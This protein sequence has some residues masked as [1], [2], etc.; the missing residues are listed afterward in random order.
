[1]TDHPLHEFVSDL[2]RRL[3][4]RVEDQPELM[5]RDAF[6]N[7]VTEYLVEDGSLDDLDPCYLHMTWGKR[8]VET[9]GYDISDDESILHL[10]V[11]EYGMFGSVLRR[12][13]VDQM[14]RRAGA[15]VD[16]CREGQHTLLEPSSPAYDMVERIHTAWSRLQSVKILVLTDGVTNIRKMKENPVGG[17]PTSVQVWDLERLHRLMGVSMA[18]EEIVINLDEL[19]HAVPCLE[20]PEQADGY[21][22]LMA[23]FPGKLLADL[24][25][26]HHSRLLQ[27]NVRAYL[28]A[29]G[30]INKKI[31]ETIKEEPGRFLAYNN[32]VS[33]TAKSATLVPGPNGPILASLT[34]LQIVNGGQTTASLHHAARKGVPLDAVHV[35]AKITLIAD[36]TLDPMIPLISKYAN[37]QNAVTSADFE[38]NSVFHVGLERLSRTTWATKPDGEQTRWYYERVRGQYEVDKNR[39]TTAAKRKQFDAEN[40]RHQ[41]FGKTDAAKFE[42]ASALRPDVACQG[43]QKCFLRWTEEENLDKREAPSAEYFRHMVAKAV[44]YN[45][46]RTLIHAQLVGGYLAQIT[47]YTVALLTERVGVLDYDLVW[48]AQRLPEPLAEVVPAAAQAVRRELVEGSGAANVTEWCKKAD[49]WS[50]VQR[51]PW[52]PPATLVEAVGAR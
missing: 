39:L 14:V 21:R 2:K 12:D 33:A 26:E 35:P 19:G 31:A 4:H 44:L 3:E 18:P 8:R 5:T 20:S 15:F 41:R 32:G 6:V 27:R 9:A 42:Y 16:F 46:I 48:R 47:A 43:G 17:L 30:K 11:A 7:L 28:Q 34:E 52:Q 38:G 51:S 10:V 49:G 29:R 36:D 45:N 40:P 50:A 24:Y 1:M 23:V 37:S 13:R 25:E 22:C